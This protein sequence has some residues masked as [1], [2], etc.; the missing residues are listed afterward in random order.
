MSRAA[1][2]WHRARESR[3]PPPGYG[4]GAAGTPCR[5]LGAYNNGH[6]PEVL[7]PPGRGSLP[8]LNGPGVD[9]R[10]GGCLYVGVLVL[11]AVLVVVV[12]LIVVALIAIAVTVFR[13]R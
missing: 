6:A 13:R 2:G 12:V 10:R 8:N 4:R 1:E 11:E 9:R 3:I 7:G 5:A